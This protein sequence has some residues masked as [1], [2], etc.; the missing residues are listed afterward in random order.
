MNYKAVLSILGRI[1]IIL[2][3][4]MLVPLAIAVYYS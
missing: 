2:G 3:M 4:L 1:F